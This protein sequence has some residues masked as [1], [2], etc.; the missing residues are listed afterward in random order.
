MPAEEFRR[1][2]VLRAIMRSKQSKCHEQRRGE[3][4]A[5]LPGAALYC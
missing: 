3:L 1:I 5:T 4:R 2:F